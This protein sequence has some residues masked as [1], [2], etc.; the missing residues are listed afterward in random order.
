MENNDIELRS[1]I[2][3]YITSAVKGMVGM[4]PFAGSLLAEIAGTIIPN[5]R[6]DRITQFAVL[7]DER[8]SQLELEHDYIRSQLSN[9]HFTDLMEEGMRQAARAI[10]KE[11]KE[12]I[13]NIIANSLNSED[14]SFEESKHLLRILGEL[15]D[16]EIIWLR[17]YAYPFMGGDEEFRSKHENILS[18]VVATLGSSQSVLDGETLQKSHKEH[19]S[20]LGLLQARYDFDKKTGQLKVDG[21]GNYASLKVRSYEITQLGKLLLREIG[22][23]PDSLP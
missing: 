23:Y 14:I 7:L 12:Y 5:Q 1:N 9:E 10:S 3:D 2:N 16:I 22:I 15:S 19:L 8:I 13:A 17:F 20:R 21:F 18:P 6:L 11:R 4:V